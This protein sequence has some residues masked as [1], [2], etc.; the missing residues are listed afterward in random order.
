MLLLVG[1]FSY[2]GRSSAEVRSESDEEFGLG[3]VDGKESEKWYHIF[4]TPSMDLTL[5][6]V[7]QKIKGR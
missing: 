2:L 7:S 5:Q 6:F 1:N 4:E 3:L